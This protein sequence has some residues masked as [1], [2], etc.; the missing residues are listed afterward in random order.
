M[1]QCR[2]SIKSGT[3]N[4]LEDIFV[5]DHNRIGGGGGE[6]KKVTA[7]PNFPEFGTQLSKQEV[8]KSAGVICPPKKW[9]LKKTFQTSGSLYVVYTLLILKT[10]R[11]NNIPPRF[12]AQ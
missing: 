3:S 4:L 9:W 8:Q 7:M 6:H 2:H 11:E 5:K 1:R 10:L 12:L